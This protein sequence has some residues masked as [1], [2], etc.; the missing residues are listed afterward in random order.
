MNTA[1]YIVYNSGGYYDIVIF[2]PLET[3]RDIAQ[4]L[5]LHVISA[6]FIQLH[7]DDSGGVKAWCRGES[8]SL[9]VESRGE[10]DAKVANRALCLDDGF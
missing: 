2:S 6:G 1:K 5:D 9:G 7:P 4:R 3:H 8:V 10:E